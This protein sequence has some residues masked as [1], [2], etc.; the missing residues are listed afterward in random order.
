MA[1]RKSFTCACAQKVQPFTIVGSNTYNLC[2]N[3]PFQNDGKGK[4]CAPASGIQGVLSFSQHTAVKIIKERMKQLKK[5][6]GEQTVYNIPTG[7]CQRC[8]KD[9]FHGWNE[10]LLGYNIDKDRCLDC[11]TKI[12][13]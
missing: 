4:L 10:Q 3:C 2:L 11:A 12:G 5:L 7:K 9:I 13:I 6:F 8:N 1:S